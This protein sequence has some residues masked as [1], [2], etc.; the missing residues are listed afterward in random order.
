MRVCV[1]LL[2]NSTG[3]PM[4]PEIEKLEKWKNEEWR[5]IRFGCKIFL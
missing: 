3:L 1:S 4:V 5:K 2:E